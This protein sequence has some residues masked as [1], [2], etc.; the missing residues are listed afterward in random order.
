L[1]GV[2]ADRLSFRVF[3]DPHQL[4]GSGSR[5]GVLTLM[6]Q[7]GPCQLRRWARN[8]RNWSRVDVVTLNPER[9]EVT[10]PAYESHDGF[11]TTLRFSG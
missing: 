6:Q 1:L 7:P 2:Q 8:T 10:A 4:S 11:V 5:N 3:V 9:T